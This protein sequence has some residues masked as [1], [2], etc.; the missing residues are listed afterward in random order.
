MKYILTALHKYN[1]CYNVIVKRLGDRAIKKHLIISAL[2]S[3]ALSGI[4][5]QAAMT[6]EANSLYQ[7]ACSAEYQQD[8]DTAVAKLTQAIQ[9]AGDD[10]LLY[11]K[12]AGVYSE[13]GEYEKA[14]VIYAKVAEM[15]PSDAFIYISVGSIYENQ[16]KYLEA[17][18]SYNKALE[19]FPEYKYNYLNIANVQYQLRDYKSAIE[20]YNKFLSTYTQHWEAREALANSYLSDGEAQQ[21]V[22][23]YENLYS[24]N[25]SGFKDYANYGIALF[26]IKNYEKAA[27]MLEKAIEID[28]DNS[29]ALISLAL[30][31]QELGKNELALAQYDVVFRQH[32]SLHSIRFDYANLLAEMGKDEAAVESYKIYIAN[33]PE[34]A[35]GYQN[36]G[37]VYK[38]LNRLD[39][40]IANFE[41]ALELQ[42]DKKDVELQEDLA[43]CYHIKKDYANALK[44]YD[45]VLLVKK[46]DYD[47]RMNKALVLH[48][49]KDYNDAIT[50]YTELLNEKE[51]PAL[52]NNLTAA[53][54]AQANEYLKAQNYSLATETYERAIQR[55]TQD[56]Y[57]YFGLA[58][59]YRACGA[60]DKATEFYEKAISLD[61]EKS[62][63]SNE[64]AD[65]ISATN[66][67]GNVKVSDTSGKIEDVTISMESLKA[68]EEAD[69]QKNKDL[70]AI[71]D[72]NYKKK[73]YDVSIRNYQDALKINPSDE[74]TLLKLGNIYKMKNDSKNAANFYKKAI[75]VNPNYADGWFN[76][77]LVY[78]NSKNASGAKEAFHRVIS[79]D[80][81]YGYA[82]YAL[83]IAYEQE[84]N[85]K[86]ALNNYKI[87]LTHNKDEVTAKTVQEKIKSL[88]K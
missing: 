19:I 78:A 63:Y 9:I 68:E 12:L 60:N 56:S 18:E 15:R 22:N 58:Q 6:P 66:M 69:L 70:I 30:S 26:K 32:P 25:V 44:Y 10:A 29:S 77:G 17:L 16:G 2:V 88:E 62:Q 76:L 73:N 65:F 79:L 7:Q 51:S 42:N 53:L 3:L 1:F 39:D 37:I 81:D 71:G 83:A 55:G 5:V 72:E 50:M 48:A 38:R 45:E 85:N 4:S 82:Y 11:T 57:A 86:E 84:G 8:Y 80:P 59:A 40:T 64:F 47:V 43:E 31:Y 46:D 87:F 54:V 52:Q 14:L 27:D 33:Y 75:F 74:V 67:A 41:K 20:N 34:D 21:A 36:I 24:R 23:E 13:M 35:R 61:P 28:P 49:M